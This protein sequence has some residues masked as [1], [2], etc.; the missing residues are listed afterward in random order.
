MTRT[1]PA[2][3]TLFLVVGA[4][5]DAN[6]VERACMRSG[7]VAASPSLCACIGSAARDTLTYREQRQAARLFS[8]P[9]EAE[10]LRMSSN[11]R[12]EA[13]WDRYRAFGETAEAMCS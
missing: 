8:D 7:Q 12:D 4:P 2:F 13:F 1:F 6:P 3:L 10:A 11:R 9:D 5:L